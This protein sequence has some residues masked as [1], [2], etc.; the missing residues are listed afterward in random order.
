MVNFH[1]DARQFMTDLLK[2]LER[3]SQSQTLGESTSGNES[4]YSVLL[5]LIGAQSQV[6]LNADQ[7]PE[8][9]VVVDPEEADSQDLFNNFF[10]VQ[11]RSVELELEQINTLLQA[12]RRRLTRY[13]KARTKIKLNRTK[14]L[15]EVPT[16]PLDAQELVKDTPEL[17]RKALS[18]EQEKLQ[19]AGDI[20]GII[21]Q[22]I[23]LQ[24]ALELSV[25]S[26]INVPE[27]TGI[28]RNQ[29]VSFM[30]STA[31]EASD[32]IERLTLFKK[33]VTSEVNRLEN[34]DQLLFDGV[35]TFS[36]EDQKLSVLQVIDV[37]IFLTDRK[38]MKYD[39]SQCKFFRT[40]KSDICTFAGEGVTGLTPLVNITDEEGNTIVGRLT[41]TTNSCKQVWG[42][43]S[44]EYYAASDDLIKALENILKG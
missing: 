34:S 21:D 12:Y 43:D 17:T 27:N 5:R 25:R 2:L 7:D 42:L 9:K 30:T 19:K 26:A 15:I 35:E 20:T 3:E 10:K 41:Q 6:I 14:K 11:V 33:E 22:D 16:T 13:S 29:L 36:G 23:Q 4:V 8:N 40:G 31:K 38:R 1:N 28:F 18:E 44:N 37:L 24:R 32:N 39:C